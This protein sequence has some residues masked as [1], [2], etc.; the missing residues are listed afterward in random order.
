MARDI[1]I[2]SSG[3]LREY[4]VLP[5]GTERGK[6]FVAC[7]EPT[8]SL[9]DLIS[10]VPSRAF[11]VA[12][13]PSRI[14]V[15]SYAEYRALVARSPAWQRVHS[16]LL[17]RL[18]LRKAE[19]EYELVALDAE[20]RYEALLARIPAIEERV[21]G[22]HIASYLAISPEYLSRLR[23]RRRDRQRARSKGRR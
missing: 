13:E 18:F 12:I 6:A 17:E 16:G 9:A 11:I 15:A 10:G 4:F 8:G 14:L 20:A 1:A 2:V 22:L 5:D 7:G 3:L 21:A 19:R 23:R